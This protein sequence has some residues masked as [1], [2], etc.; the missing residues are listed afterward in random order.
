[1]NYWQFKFKD[2]FWK[3]FEQLELGDTF[4]TSITENEKNKLN[5]R[6]GDIIFW[7][8]SGIKKNI[9]NG[10]YFVTEIISDVKEDGEYNNGYS[11][12][13]RIIQI[14]TNNP[15]VLENGFETLLENTKK[16]NYVQYI[17]YLLQDEDKGQILYK[18]LIKNS[19]YVNELETIQRENYKNIE[20][21][22]EKN[23]NNGT[24]FNPF[25][26]MNLIKH[27]VKHLS[28]ISNLLNPNGTHFQ[29]DKFLKNF[30]T[31]LLEYDL[32]DANPYLL[33]VLNS[34]RN[35]IDI[36]VQTERSIARD[37]DGK[38]GRID[39]WIENNDYIIAIEG[40]TESSDSKNQLFKYDK[41]LR[42]QNKPY[43]LIYLTMNGEKPK[44][45]NP[46]KLQIISFKEDIN[47]F[48]QYT[49]QEK[50]PEKI[51]STL[52]EYQGSLIT[53][54][55]QFAPDWNYRLDIINE[56]TKDSK[57]YEKYQKIKDLYYRNT[58]EF[59]YSVVEDIANNF[60]YA[61]AKIERD[62]FVDLYKKTCILFEEY[63]FILDDASD[64]LVNDT[65]VAIFKDIKKIYDARKKRINS[66][67][68]DIKKF[69]DQIKI[70]FSNQ[71]SAWIISNS[72]N[73]LNLENQ[74][75]IIEL[76]PISE[77]YSINIYKFLDVKYK[78]RKINDI[79]NT[80]EKYLSETN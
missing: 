28:F 68:D 21:L 12:E 1:M 52:Q 41:Y 27:E 74:N 57:S 20:K 73:N 2:E 39:I 36:K 47:K 15:F 17:R 58:K 66:N 67:N 53:Y 18:Q 33:N 50:I 77:F 48:I 55:H 34:T 3:E 40:K 5:N 69:K 30:I 38:S 24:M 62:F 60:E 25:L 65:I 43:L 42:E 56:I 9:T 51:R 10:I 29:G 8:R 75:S 49:L 44:N 31:V 19:P 26:D 70:L 46:E 16:G 4:T 14:L 23:I 61:K 78:N 35:N 45:S 72:L 59:K 32:N 63:N 79:K 76:L 7:Y 71:N 11:I 80:I 6:V 37:K 13:N 64:I 22:K 54:L